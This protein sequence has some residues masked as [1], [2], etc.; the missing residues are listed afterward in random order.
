VNRMLDLYY[1]GLGCAV[2][3]LFW[4]FTRACDKL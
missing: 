4:A 1:V 3:V 2:L